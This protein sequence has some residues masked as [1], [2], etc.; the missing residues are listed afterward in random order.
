MFNI[1]IRIIFFKKIVK[2]S[3]ISIGQCIATAFRICRYGSYG[4][5]LLVGIPGI[6]YAFER[7]G[8]IPPLRGYYIKQ[9]IQ[10]FGANEINCA[11]TEGE[12]LSKE[13]IIDTIIS[14]QQEY[15]RKQEMRINSA[16]KAAKIDGCN[17]KLITERVVNSF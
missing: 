9:H 6:D 2:N 16:Y 10:Y 11:I 8:H 1:I 13:G 15:T 4:V 5:A 14:N 12:I 3:P 17:S 7:N